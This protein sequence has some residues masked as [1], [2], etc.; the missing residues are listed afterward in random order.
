MTT[1]SNNSYEMAT[2]TICSSSSINNNIMIDIVGD[3]IDYGPFGFMERFDPNFICNASDHYVSPIWIIN[4]IGSFNTFCLRSIYICSNK[5]IIRVDTLMLNS[6]KSVVGTVNN[7]VKHWLLSFIWRKERSRYS[8]WNILTSSIKRSTQRGELSVWKITDTTL[9]Y[10]LNYNSVGR[11]TYPSPKLFFKLSF[12]RMRCKLGILNGPN[13][14]DKKL[15]VNLFDTMRL[16][17]A[18]FTTTFK[19]LEKVR[20]WTVFTV[21]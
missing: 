21:Y 6:P 10:Y 2:L 3:T 14:E 7:S 17:A 15:F 9:I 11:H 19:T 4:W 13:D 12:P 16:S 18:D 5:R 20:T 8:W 1:D